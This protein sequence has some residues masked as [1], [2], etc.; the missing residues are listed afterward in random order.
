MP[1]VLTYADFI[2]CFNLKNASTGL[3]LNTG[4]RL[5][6]F[7]QSGN[8]ILGLGYLALNKSQNYW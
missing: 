6:G 5:V 4:Y 2:R 8:L 1:Q 3:Y 7:Y